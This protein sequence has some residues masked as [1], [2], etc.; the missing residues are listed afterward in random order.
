MSQRPAH[1]R[2][3]TGMARVS[4]QDTSIPFA[5][6]LGT[7]AYDEPARTSN[8][9]QNEVVISRQT[10]LGGHVKDGNQSRKKT[11]NSND[12]GALLFAPGNAA[13]NSAAWSPSFSDSALSR[14]TSRVQP[15]SVVGMEPAFSTTK[16]KAPALKTPILRPSVNM[17]NLPQQRTLL[18]SPR[19]AA[20]AL[21][22]G[23]YEETVRLKREA[24]ENYRQHLI[25]QEPLPSGF[26]N[27]ATN[28]GFSRPPSPARSSLPIGSPSSLVNFSVTDQEEI[29]GTSGLNAHARA[30]SGGDSQN[31]SEVAALLT[32]AT[33]ATT[34]QALPH[35]SALAVSESVVLVDP[36]AV[37]GVKGRGRER[38]AT[39]RSESESR[40]VFHRG[41]GGG[42]G[43]STAN[44]VGPVINSFR[45]H[46]ISEGGA[47]KHCSV[48]A[49]GDNDDDDDER[50]G[51]VITRGHGVA[52]LDPSGAE[53]FGGQAF[54]GTSKRNPPL[55]RNTHLAYPN[56][57]QFELQHQALRSAPTS[58][59]PASAS[60][61]EGTPE[62]QKRQ[63][64]EQW[65]HK[66]RSHEEGSGLAHAMGERNKERAAP[67]PSM[68]FSMVGT[69]H[70]STASQP[71]T[72]Q[73]QQADEA[74]RSPTP[75]G[76]GGA[77]LTAA[78]APQT[79]VE[80]VS[81]PAHAAG[82]W[83]PGAS[84]APS[85]QFRGRAA[86]AVSLPPLLASQLN[87]V[88]SSRPLRP[89]RLTAKR[90]SESGAT[91]PENLSVSS[92]TS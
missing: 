69:S 21:N 65:P 73:G 78:Q 76:S 62:P 49:A 27:Y 51:G 24:L 5:W 20:R 8:P 30:V 52:P 13:P 17:A 10:L 72:R 16:G 3:A 25:A 1:P 50:Q 91:G 19:R 7:T 44:S 42:G 34:N 47:R 6:L 61:R 70:T 35:V 41:G 83:T 38:A 48:A 45:E 59:S 29:T 23:Y 71:S 84:I 63:I 26:A 92:G 15:L 14:F 75:P 77:E 80:A 64:H 81:A 58:S 55:L 66:R 33:T 67:P 37:V 4:K 39:T 60:Q 85:S 12:V 89:S 53:L 46:S 90:V 31:Q 32:S 74:L 57:Q 82:E 87:P 54:R 18:D 28:G 22:Q 43:A 79:A 56:Q 11:A 86:E 36:K 40:D 68:S 2:E 88:A 9:A